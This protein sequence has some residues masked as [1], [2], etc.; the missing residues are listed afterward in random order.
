VGELKGDAALGCLWLEPTG[1]S[2]G[3]AERIS[4]EWP[5]GYSAT[6]DPVPQLLDEG[7]NVVAREGDVVEA[8]GGTTESIASCKVSEQVW[9]VNTV[10]PRID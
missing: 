8:G 7:G 2:E 10:E 9:S 6:F 1:I 4:V 3:L 5:H